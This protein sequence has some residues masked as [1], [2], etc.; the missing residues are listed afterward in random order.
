MGQ[1]RGQ[2]D[3][4]GILLASGLTWY[5]FRSRLCGLDQRSDPGLRAPSWVLLAWQLR[6]CLLPIPCFVRRDQVP[7]GLR[8]RVRLAVGHAAVALA[9]DLNLGSKATLVGSLSTGPIRDQTKGQT[10][11][12]EDPQDLKLGQ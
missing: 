7:A 4:R 2:E 12:Q 3:P 11:G 8:D 10:R 5:G 6:L 9:L 1:A